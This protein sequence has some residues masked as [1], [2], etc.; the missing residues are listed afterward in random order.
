[1]QPDFYDPQLIKKVPPKRTQTALGP[2]EYVDIGTG[3]V[4]VT[5]HGAMGGYDQ[6]LIL[7]Q[8]IGAPTYRYLALSR[9]GYLGT[10]LSSGKSSAAQGD[11]V[12]ALLDALG[13]DKAGMMAVSGGGPSALQF[14][15]RHPDRC[16]GLV[17]VST[18]ADKVEMP[19]PFGFKVMTVMARLPWFARRIGQK[20]RSDLKA[21]AQR[22]IRD[23]EV[24]ERT[25]NDAKTWPLFSTMMLSTYD[26]MHQRIVG[27]DNDIRITRTERY[28][29]ETLA[30]PVMVVHGTVDQ[31]VQYDVHAKLY[32]QR[33]PQTELVTVDNGEHVSIFTHRELVQP[34]VQ[35]FMQHHFA[36]EALVTA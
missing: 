15:L 24:L 14:G 27:T 10:P 20:A 12:A 34:Q 23:P 16:N 28:P 17:L 19:I 9:P 26:R 7:A 25:V 6:S 30:V 4:V 5:A 2:I 29:L 35:R 11:L 36:A 21:A 1:M 33:V 3:P 31:L 32:A 8:T 18:C 22:S 13:I